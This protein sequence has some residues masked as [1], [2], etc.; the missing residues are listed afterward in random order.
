MNGGVVKQNSRGLS[1][2]CVETLHP[3]KSEKVRELFLPW[4]MLKMVLTLL[5]IVPF[6]DI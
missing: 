3:I 2:I 1:Q 6:I 4:L 5:E